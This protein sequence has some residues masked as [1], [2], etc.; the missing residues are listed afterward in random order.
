M[1]IYFFKLNIK[2]MI[3]CGIYICHDEKGLLYFRH[4]FVTERIFMDMIGSLIWTHDP[5]EL[6][7]QINDHMANYQR[8]SNVNRIQIVSPTRSLCYP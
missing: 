5:T 4:H 8:R 6:Q 3:R 1:L 2:E 7:Q